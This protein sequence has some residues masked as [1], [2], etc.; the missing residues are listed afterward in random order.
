M[1]VTETETEEV[2]GNG[3]E[4]EPHGD[5]VRMLETGEILM[6]ISRDSYLL[7]PPKLGEY[8]LLRQITKDRAVKLIELRDEAL[9]AKST[10]VDINQVDDLRFMERFIELAFNGNEEFN[11]LSD[12]KLPEEND[13]PTW[14]VSD[15]LQAEMLR[16][17]Q[18]VPLD[19]GRS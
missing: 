16:H 18:S 13:W 19:S 9:K 10:T 2:S 5:R 15:T 3:V 14:L 1:T 8:R 11:G 12:R 6:V 4:A 7:R 17:W